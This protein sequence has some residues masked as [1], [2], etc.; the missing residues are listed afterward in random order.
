M[1]AAAQRRAGDPEIEKR[2]EKWQISGRNQNVA[3]ETTKERDADLSATY[4]GA[5]IE[6]CRA[7]WLEGDPLD[8]EMDEGEF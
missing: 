5:S 1:A 2:L 4:R 3:V 8:L 6:S 7:S